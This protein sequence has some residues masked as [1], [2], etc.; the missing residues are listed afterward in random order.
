[1]SGL[2]APATTVLHLA[3]RAGLAL[4]LV[5]FLAAY[6]VLGL[7]LTPPVGGALAAVALVRKIHILATRAAPRWRDASRGS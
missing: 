2:V 3:G 1:M 5:V 7:L 6:A 4:A